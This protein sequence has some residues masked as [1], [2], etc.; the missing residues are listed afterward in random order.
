MLA[1]THHLSELISLGLAQL[2]A[3]PYIGVPL[4]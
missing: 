3:V 1:A 2:D 4:V